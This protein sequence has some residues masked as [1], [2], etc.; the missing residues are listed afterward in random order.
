MHKHIKKIYQRVLSICVT[1][2]LVILGII[3]LNVKELRYI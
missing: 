3:T 1:V 2:L